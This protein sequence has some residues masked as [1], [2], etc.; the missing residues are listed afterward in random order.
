M[1]ENEKNSTDELLKEYKD[2][3]VALS[4][5]IPWFEAKQ[6]QNVMSMY[7]PEGG[8]PSRQMAIPTYDSTLLSFVNHF[9]T[10]KHLNKNYH[11]VYS[12]YSIRSVADEFRMIDR[13][14][15]QEMDILFSILS[16]Y[17]IKGRT[18]GMVWKE[19]V[20]NGVFLACVSKMRELIEFWDMPLEQ[21][22]GMEDK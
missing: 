12:R 17:I 3:V 8:V 13:A 7:T 16:S 9:K 6:G 22:T 19:G 11:Y 15:I 21:R 18:K 4:K 14:R 10:S 1:F 2:E 20:E 5:Y